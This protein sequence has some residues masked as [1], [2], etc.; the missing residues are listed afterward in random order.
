MLSRRT[1]A[2]ET[3]RAPRGRGREGRQARPGTQ[4]KLGRKVV[5]MAPRG[6]FRS[7][8]PTPPGEGGQ[9][10][11]KGRGRRYRPAPGPAHQT[12]RG[13]G[14]PP[15]GNW[16]EEAPGGGWGGLP[17]EGTAPPRSHAQTMAVSGHPG[18]PGCRKRA[19]L[20]GAK[21]VGSRCQGL[22]RDDRVGNRPGHQS[23]CSRRSPFERGEE[24][25]G[26]STA[27]RA[28]QRQAGRFLEGNQRR[29]AELAQPW[30]R[31]RPAYEQRLQLDRE[32]IVKAKKVLG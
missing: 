23:T 4:V 28:D 15:A 3:I 12:A 6:G 31:K 10:S 2:L 32:E 26:R 19:G 17:R 25:P 16:A 7:R 27:P 8:R 29:L 30:S 24:G 20:L 22:A 21:P 14:S 9:H 13:R 1:A 5:Q 11:A 18:S